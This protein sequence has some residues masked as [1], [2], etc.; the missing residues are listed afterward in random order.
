MDDD[1]AWGRI[2]LAVAAIAMG[3]AA[4]TGAPTQP[5]AA[6]AGTP[7]APGA[8]RTL[9][10]YRWRLDSATDASGARIEAV[11]PSG[12][13]A[14]TFAFAGPQVVV[15]G[16]CNSMRGGFLI[17][18]EGRLAFGRMAATMKACDAPLMR[19][20]AA[21]AKL[22]AEPMSAALATGEPP[23]LRLTTAANETL[24][25]S[26]EMTPEARY[27]PPTIAF[28]EVAPTRVACNHPLIRD[29]T[30]LQVRDRVYDAQ[31][32][33]GGAPGPWRAFSGTIEGY[34][35]HEGV[36][37]VLRVKRFA[38]NPPPADGSSYLYVLDLVVQS[39]VVKP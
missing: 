10:R 33:P 6:P 19:A 26:G 20:D 2:A 7:L 25:L 12:P 32:L 16:G 17:P 5:V 23:R 29:A 38:R 8:E 13:R 1:R 34:T 4:C 21:L 11:S 31:G 14:F 27:G 28:L 3:V 37:N 35:H 36:R 9:E 18:A 24:A 22:L 15:D 39:E 30:C